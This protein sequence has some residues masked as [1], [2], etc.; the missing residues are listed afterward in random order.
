MSFY[1][2]LTD[3]A[4]RLS[5]LPQMT[6]LA[7]SLQA[8]S[9]A[10]PVA[11]MQRVAPLLPS[12]HAPLMAALAQHPALSSPALLYVAEQP[13]QA[14]QVYDDVRQWLPAERVLFFPA[15]TLPLYE[16]AP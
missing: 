13:N 1:S 8:A 3:I 4:T 14:S 5:A 10:R 15:L 6:T 16:P 11:P 7:R 12:A 9:V 2:M